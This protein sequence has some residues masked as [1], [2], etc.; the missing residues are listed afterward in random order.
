MTTHPT[1]DAPALQLRVTAER[2]ARRAYE[3]ARLR[4]GAMHG[5]AVAGVLALLA[6]ALV[7]RDAALALVGLFAVW[8]ALDWR[9]GAWLRGARLGVPAGVL[10]WL[11]PTAAIDGCCRLGCALTG[12]ACCGVTGACT[13]F[14]VVLGLAVGVAVTRGKDPWRVES[15]L[16]GA[17]ALIAA[18]APR[19]ATLVVG[20]SVGLV[21][22][23]VLGAALA[24]TIGVALRPRTA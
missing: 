6:L 7:G 13:M 10:S 9:G 12:G 23:V 17:L 24:T 1:K 3:L 4:R 15:A 22:G 2:A 11:V 19:C 20:E 8:T 16:G 21:L 5:G 18:A 14:G